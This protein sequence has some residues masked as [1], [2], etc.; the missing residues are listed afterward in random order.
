MFLLFMN[1]RIQGTVRDAGMLI[2]DMFA[3]ITT[4]YSPRVCYSDLQL[5][6]QTVRVVI[7]LNSQREYMQNLFLSLRRVLGKSEVK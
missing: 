5:P 3:C 7:F 6:Y 2:C 4:E 1:I